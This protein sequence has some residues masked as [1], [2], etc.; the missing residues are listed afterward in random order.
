MNVIQLI[1]AGFLGLILYYVGFNYSI[2]YTIILHFVNNCLIVLLLPYLG[3]RYHIKNLTLMVSLALMAVG[4]LGALKCRPRSRIM[5][6]F[7]NN[8]GK[9]EEGAYKAFLLNPWVIIL[10]LFD[11][12][13]TVLIVYMFSEGIIR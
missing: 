1:S 7:K 10:I 6:F 13:F 3:N 5:D 12:V 8:Y 9:H 11:I 2:I 4:I